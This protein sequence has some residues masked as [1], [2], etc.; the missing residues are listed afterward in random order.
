[1]DPGQRLK[2]VIRQSGRT[3]AEVAAA[4]GEHPMWVS[5]R[6]TGH[7]QINIQDVPRLASSLALDEC[8]LLKALIHGDDGT[9]TSTRMPIRRRSLTVAEDIEGRALQAID[10]EKLD[11][12]LAIIELLEKWDRG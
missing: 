2:Q 6:V 8:D 5:H 11:R 10:P 3:Q 9:T 1:M 7:S 4:I 12:A